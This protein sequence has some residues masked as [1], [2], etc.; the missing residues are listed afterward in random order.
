MGPL[1]VLYSVR[2]VHSGRLDPATILASHRVNTLL[3]P[4]G[5]F[6]DNTA[7]RRSA[8][9]AFVQGTSPWT[10]IPQRR[11]GPDPAALFLGAGHSTRHLPHSANG[12]GASSRFFTE[13]GIQKGSGMG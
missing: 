4:P 11:L 9:W 3:Q 12:H 13:G 10:S 7:G 6:R 8:D 1:S 2:H 5:G